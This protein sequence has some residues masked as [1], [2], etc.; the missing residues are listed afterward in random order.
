MEN[1]NKLL[2]LNLKE[3]DLERLLPRMGYDY[4]SGN[5]IIPAWR[6]DI[7]HE[8]DII[9]D[10]AI[11]YGYNNFTPEIP[12]VATVGQESKE[13]KI[14]SKISEI[15]IGLD[16][17][18]LS[19]YHLI[20][21]SE[22][23]NQEKAIELENS[24]TEFKYLRPNLTIPCLRTYSENKDHEYPQRVFEIGTI[25]N[26]DHEKTESKISEQ[27]NL[28]IASSPANF[29]EIKQILDFLFKSI[30]LNYELED[31]KSS[32]TIEGRTGSIL[33][34]NKEIGIIGEIHPETL[35]N[36]GIKFPVSLIEISL[37]EIFEKLK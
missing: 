13:S 27:T 7:L 2:G 23:F 16:L 6:T 12:N 32:Y 18:E 17:I 14:K 24:K 35:K 22:I 34:N 4:K 26:H 29:T 15:L 21:K 8:V 33:F 30:N 37:E 11:A 19:S 3:K 20:K 5:A 31:S 10:T 28:L 9:E 36:W 1:T 25:F